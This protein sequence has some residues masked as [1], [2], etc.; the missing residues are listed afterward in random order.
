[1]ALGFQAIAAYARE[2]LVRSITFLCICLALAPCPSAQPSP[3]TQRVAKFALTAG[4]ATLADVIA[5][6]PDIERALQ[7]PPGAAAG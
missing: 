5:V 2:S 3:A 4:E 1:M 6:W 7:G